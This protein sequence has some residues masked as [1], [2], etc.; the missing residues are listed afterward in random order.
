MLVATL[1]LQIL[2]ITTPLSDFIQTKNLDFIQEWK[3]IEISYL[4]LK[5]YEKFDETCQASKTICISN[6]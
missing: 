1:F 6:D 3:L 5:V 4:K 2:K